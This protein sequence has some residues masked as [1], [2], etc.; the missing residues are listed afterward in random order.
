MEGPETVERLLSRLSGV[1]LG[2]YLVALPP[3]TPASIVE[4]WPRAI[5][6]VDDAYLYH[7]GLLAPAR[8]EAVGEAVSRT[9]LRLTGQ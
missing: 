9:R 8:L 5:A 7:L 1:R 3:A 2:G 4:E 6:N